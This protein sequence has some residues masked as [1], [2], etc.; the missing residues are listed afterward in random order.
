M[1]SVPFTVNFFPDGSTGLLNSYQYRQYLRHSALQKIP[2]VPRRKY[3]FEVHTQCWS[4]WKFESS[5]R[6]AEEELKENN[7]R[8]SS[9]DS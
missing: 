8:A 7:Q 3:P 9:F 1:I 2:R 5:V 6:D 4:K